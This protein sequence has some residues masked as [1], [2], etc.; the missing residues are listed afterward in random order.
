[1]ISMGFTISHKMKYL[2]N[3]RSMAQSKRNAG[4][5]HD[6][7][8]KVNHFKVK[9]QEIVTWFFYENII[10]KFAFSWLQVLV[11]KKT[12]TVL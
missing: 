1:M 6:I 7:D 11:L 3:L 2:R 8:S 9:F 10:W 4:S 12:D 5:C